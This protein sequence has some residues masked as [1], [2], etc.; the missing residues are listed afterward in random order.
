[1]GRRYKRDQDFTDSFSGYFYRNDQETPI[2]AFFEGVASSRDG[3]IIVGRS[4]AYT[5]RYE[6]GQ[7]SSLAEIIPTAITPDGS[8]VVGRSSHRV[9]VKVSGGRTTYLGLLGCKLNA[10][11]P[12]DCDR[13][14]ESVATGVSSD[15][16]RVVGYST[17]R[18]GTVHP[19]LYEERVNP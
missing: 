10:A 15:G 5:N 19:F 6:N 16:K 11:T 2:D 8:V 1:M 14:T 4:S 17:T 12:P 3:S 13:F 18:D 7:I 9:A